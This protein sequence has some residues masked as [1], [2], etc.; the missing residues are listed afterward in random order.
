MIA[1]TPASG[2]AALQQRTGSSSDTGNQLMANS[3]PQALGSALGMA[4]RKS[5]VRFSAIAEEEEDFLE[6]ILE[7]SE[8]DSAFQPVQLAASEM[9]APSASPTSSKDEELESL[10]VILVFSVFLKS[11]CVKKRFSIA[12]ICCY[13]RILSLPKLVM[14]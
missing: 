2:H 12:G 3:S 6:R 5:S 8:S 11:L 9:Q 1:A 7:R 13:Y 10:Q 14:E 4:N